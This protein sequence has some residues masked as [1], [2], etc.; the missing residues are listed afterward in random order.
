MSNYIETAKNLQ[1]LDKIV[2]GESLYTKYWC[3]FVKE[4]VRWF[5]LED[6][7]IIKDILFWCY[8]FE[9]D[10]PKSIEVSKSL[11]NSYLVDKATFGVDCPVMK[12]L[13]EM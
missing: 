3:A 13:K 9:E 5:T 1:A 4:N 2:V 12:L 7:I 11:L 10:I 6:L 8:E